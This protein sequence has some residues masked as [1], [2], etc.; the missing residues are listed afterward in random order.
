MTPVRLEPATPLSRVKLSTTEPHPVKKV[1]L[2]LKG[3]S[4]AICDFP[5][6]GGGG[7]C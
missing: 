6:G 5:G 7:G 3:I 2:L 1:Q 4:I